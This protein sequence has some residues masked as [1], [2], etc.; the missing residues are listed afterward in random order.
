MNI[1]IMVDIEGISGIYSSEQTRKNGLFYE[2]G[3]DLITAEVNACA[4]ACKAAG[5]DKVYVRDAHGD[6]SFIRYEALSTVVDYLVQG[7]AG[8]GVRFAG[9]E[10]CDAVILLG[11]HAMSGT[12]RGIL[13]HTM[14]L[15]RH[16][17]FNGVEL[18][19]T[20]IDAAIAAE[21]GKPVIMVSGDDWACAEA[22]RFLPWVTTCEVKRGLTRTKAM[23]LEASRAHRL[24]AEKT[25]EA[26]ARISKCDLFRITSPMTVRLLAKDSE[27]TDRTWESR[28][29]EEALGES[30]KYWRKPQ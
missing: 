12:E 30:W 10:D 24:I 11:Y 26:I 9:I 22:K 8:G 4:E 7:S 6:G 16:Y 14:S 17:L 23:L 28:T 20:A 21:Y 13:S 25:R 27:Y 19:E 1:Y 15:D 18:G 5:A 29:V 3:R 2:Q